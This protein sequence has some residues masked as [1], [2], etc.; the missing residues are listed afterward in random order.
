M[1]FS[2]SFRKT[3]RES[4]VSAN[5]NRSNNKSLEDLSPESSMANKDSV[6]D[7]IR[8]LHKR[9][10]S[11]YKLHSRIT[12]MIVL[13]T[14]FILCTLPSFITYVLDATETVVNYEVAMTA[15]F[16]AVYLYIIA[17]PIILLKYLPN[18]Q[19]TLI[20]MIRN[21]SLTRIPKVQRRQSTN[22]I[23]RKP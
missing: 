6:T 9:R 21:C 23:I 8:Y 11:Q 5:I 19:S 12:F 10:R 4:V 15:S 14:T 22:K 3:P 7:S 17:C 13:S 1:G 16:T 18:L 20:V 2:R